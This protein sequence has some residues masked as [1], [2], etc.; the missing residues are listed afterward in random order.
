MSSKQSARNN[1]RARRSPSSDAS[2]R[3]RF[4]PTSWGLFAIVSFLTLGALT[5][6]EV[7][8][9]A[10]RVLPVGYQSADESESYGYAP[11]SD[12]SQ[13]RYERRDDVRELPPSRVPAAQSSSSSSRAP[14]A[15]AQSAALPPSPARSNSSY[16]APDASSQPRYV[17]PSTRNERSVQKTFSA[18]RDKDAALIGAFLL[19]L[20]PENLSSKTTWRYNERENTLTVYGPE[21]A[22]ELSEKLLE[23]FSEPLY[24]AFLES[25]S[26][27]E[28][29]G[30][31]GKSPREDR[32]DP[33]AYES[34]LLIL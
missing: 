11:A 4:L 22:I 30:L 26:N 9:G 19:R 34:G 21:K 13:E 20:L 17:E 28:Y 29:V 15:S 31:V 32:V 33:T 23:D 27:G 7:A 16:N 24:Q 6:V 8:Q 12:A 1:S 14:A 3:S 18:P 25:G 2:R 10:R 5:L